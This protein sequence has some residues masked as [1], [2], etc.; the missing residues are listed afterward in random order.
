MSSVNHDDHLLEMLTKMLA[1]SLIA[2]FPFCTLGCEK[3]EV[4]SRLNDRPK[5]SASHQAT[6]S[7]VIEPARDKLNALTNQDVSDAK[8]SAARIKFDRLRAQLESGKSVHNEL[9][10]AFKEWAENDPASALKFFE[11]AGN[12][13]RYRHSMP[14]IMDVVAKADPQILK[15]WIAGDLSWLPDHRDRSEMLKSGLRSLGR[16]APAM[17]L[18][19]FH[20]LK[21]G[22]LEKTSMAEAAFVGIASAD[23]E[24]AMREAAKLDEPLSD[25]ALKGISNG[26]ISIEKSIEAATKISDSRIRSDALRQIALTSER[27]YQDGLEVTLMIDHN[28]TRMLTLREL[29]PEWYRK[30]AAEATKALRALDP[31]QRAEVL[32]AESSIMPKLIEDDPELIVSSL[33]EIYPNAI[34]SKSFQKAIAQLA[35]SH[36]EGASRVIA[37]LP[38]SPLRSRLLEKMKEK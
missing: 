19:V 13:R 10:D 6:Q 14:G 21:V 32:L 35:E 1:A 26:F 11:D 2:A 4:S 17:A 25:H 31:S 38:D 33:M 34:N 27:T 15:D 12:M 20:S 37:N 5:T 16:N 28:G 7:K 29:V 22:K 23:V 3:N 8:R 24:L 9:H 36:P 18:D 30:D